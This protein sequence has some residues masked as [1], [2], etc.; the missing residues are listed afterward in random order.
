MRAT[1]LSAPTVTNVVKDL[2]DEDLIEPLGEGESTGGRPP[3]LIRF[4]SSRGCLLAV[5]LTATSL[6]FLLTDLDGAEIDAETVALIGRPTTPEA[7]CGYIGN[8]VERLL[9][10]QGKT[11]Q[12]LLSLIVGVPAITDVDHGVVLFISNLEGWQSVPLRDL[13]NK[14]VDC[15]VLIENDTNLAAKGEMYRGAARDEYNFV[16]I[17]IGANVGAGIVLNG[18]IHHGTQW[19]AGEIA[20]LRLPSISRR[21]PA[22]HEFGELEHVLTTSGMLK[23]WQEATLPAG[24]RRVKKLNA[25]GILQLAQEGDLRA[26]EIVQHRAQIIADIVVNLSLILNPSLILL[27][28]EIGSHAVLLRGVQK[29]LEDSE[30]AVPRIAAGTLGERAVLWGAVAIAL[31]GIASILIPLPVN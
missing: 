6:S 12:Q 25:S 26:Q 18:A 27:S 2:I 1:G 15:P 28:G 21:P 7:V 3:D 13:L 22:I 16:L 30:F 14:I 24:K 8:V 11:R 31:E 10:R 20:Y 4:N 19:S 9:T 23:S 17:S 5:D 29:Q